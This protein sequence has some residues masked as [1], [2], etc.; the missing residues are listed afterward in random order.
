MGGRV[1]LELTSAGVKH[2]GYVYALGGLLA[3]Q[4]PSPG[5]IQNV[6]WLHSDPVT[7]NRRWTGMAGELL[8][9]STELD[10]LGVDAGPA[11]PPPGQPPGEPDRLG[12]GGDIMNPSN[13]C[14]IEQIPAPCGVVIGLLNTGRGAPCPDNLCGPRYIDGRWHTLTFD[15][16]GLRYRR[17]VR[18]HPVNRP[19]NNDPGAIVINVKGQASGHW[20]YVNVKQETGS[21]IPLGNLS[22]NVADIL[23][24]QG[25]SDFISNLIN[26]AR[27]LTG[28]KPYS[29]SASELVRMVNRQDDGGYFFVNETGAGSG[30][31]SAYGEIRYGD[32]TAQIGAKA[33]RVG[34]VNAG[35]IRATQLDYALTAIHET[36]HLAG[37]GRY[38]DS[39]LATAAQIL[40]NAPGFPS[41]VDPNDR[42]AVYKYGGYWNQQLREHCLSGR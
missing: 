24:N 1:L 23:F 30:G 15:N 2:V 27:Q 39:V 37:G 34:P 21:V 25:C 35:I 18:D 19:P 10:P 12:G 5:G 8:P 33:V 38:T 31:G 42:F 41:N 36:V 3:E 9:G 20:E 29:Y 13:G 32:A 40:T 11:Q 17:W 6:A 26:V 7:G 22:Q 14:G 28:V 4:R 16:E